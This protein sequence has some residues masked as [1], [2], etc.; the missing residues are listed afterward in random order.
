MYPLPTVH[1][2][3][4][5]ATEGGT[6]VDLTT[7]QN[8]KVGVTSPAPPT[9]LRRTYGGLCNIYLYNAD[10]GYIGTTEYCENPH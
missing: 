6:G 2:P 9:L 5:L 8:K 3:T 4:F 7:F 10:Q 1:N